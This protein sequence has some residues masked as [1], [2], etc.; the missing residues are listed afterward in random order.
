MKSSHWIVIAIVACILGFLLGYSI[1][2]YQEVGLL[3][4]KA[5]EEQELQ[6]LLPE[7]VAEE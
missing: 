6:Q 1:P 5:P 7:E 4:G 3:G 2:A